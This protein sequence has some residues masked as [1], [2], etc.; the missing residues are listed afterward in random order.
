MYLIYHLLS[1]EQTGAKGR[2]HNL[3]P[4]GRRV[5]VTGA[6]GMKNTPDPAIGL[7]RASPVFGQLPLAGTEVA[8]FPRRMAPSV[9]SEGC[10]GHWRDSQLCCAARRFALLFQGGQ[11]ASCPP[12]STR[13]TSRT[14]RSHLTLWA[15]TRLPWE[16]LFVEMITI[17]SHK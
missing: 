1:V 15:E 10:A 8:T 5:S 6:A 13:G 9:S 17:L 3:L 11:D 2:I 16:A 4:S 14:K 12:G 7:C